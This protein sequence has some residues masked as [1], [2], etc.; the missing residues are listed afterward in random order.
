MATK[1][2]R[3][4][5]KPKS[6]SSARPRNTR[7]VQPKSG[8]GWQVTGGDAAYDVPTQ[9]QGMERAKQDLQRSGG[10]ELFVKGLD[11]KVREKNTIGRPDPRKSRG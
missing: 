5:A 3:K 6:T 9:E 7:T 2:T 1:K 10:G 4:T 11:G 8:G